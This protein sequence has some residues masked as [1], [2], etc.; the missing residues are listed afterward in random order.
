MRFFVSVILFILPFSMYTHEFFHEKEVYQGDPITFVISPVEES[1]D[2]TF[3]LYNKDDKEILTVVGFNYYLFEE[4]TSMILGLGGIPSNLPPGKYRVKA[5]GIG[6]FDSFYFERELEVLDRNFPGSKLK[7]NMKMN[8][9][10][11]GKRDP[12]RDVQAKR[13]WKAVSRFFPYA[14][15][16]QDELIQPVENARHTSPYG[17]K[18]TTIYPGGKESVSV[19]NGEDYAIKI[20]TPI[21]S[22]ASGRVILAE[23]RIVTG[24]TVIVEHLPGVITLYY[25]LN[26]LAV[27][28]NELLKVGD[29]IGEVGTT[30]FSTGPHL[31][32]ELR[33]STVPVDPK[34]FINKPLIDKSLII[35]MINSTNNKRGG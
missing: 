20:G 21:F 4:R 15:Y 6:V 23:N 17:F 7:A 28:N 5:V 26:S 27:V 3:T 18:R 13:W 24:N 8:K 30:G 11:N 22:D 34:Q 1:F 16:H 14:L 2:Y 19:H 35:S 33:F 12:E 9:I 10:I 32:W 25:H 29:K 31:H